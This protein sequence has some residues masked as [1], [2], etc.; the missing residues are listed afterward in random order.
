MTD[1]SLA[2]AE[3]SAP[4]TY[5]KRVCHDADSHVMEPAEWLDAFIDEIKQDPL[6][7]IH[8]TPNERIQRL[9]EEARQ[10]F[11]NDELIAKAQENI[12]AN[13]KGVV[14]YGAFDPQERSKALDQLG[15]ASQLVFAT[16]S[17][18]VFRTYKDPDTLYAGARAHNRAMAKF[19]AADPRL[20]AVGY[21]PLN[22]TQRACEEFDYAWELGCRTFWVPVQPAGERSPAHTDL[23]PLWQRFAD[24]DV[25]FMLHIGPGSRTLPKEYNENG[26]PR[27]PDLH[28]GGENL[29]FLDYVVLPHSAEMFIGAMI[30]GGAFERFPTLRCGILEFGAYWVPGFLKT[31]D[32]GWRAFKRTDPLVKDMALKPSE[33]FRRQVRV[34]P[35]PGEDAGALIRDAGAELFLFSSDYPHNEGTD[36]PIGRFER[37]FEG[38]SEADKE[39]FYRTNYEEL[40]GAALPR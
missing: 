33:Y 19:C 9:T 16:H 10:R 18:G 23:D 22:D 14:A 13:R 8:R 34:G 3:R 17:L 36:D 5:A 28:G 2:A 32:F 37:T 30:Y 31:L 7:S 11:G 35:F 21:L 38:I 15:F 1:A 40:L 6:A 29:R 26:R 27:S 39:R 20:I 4:E 25:P 24:R 12:I